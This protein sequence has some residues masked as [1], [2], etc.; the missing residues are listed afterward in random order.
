MNIFNYKKE[1]A[2]KIVEGY[3]RPNSFKSI[4]SDASIINLFFPK[5]ENVLLVYDKELSEDENEAIIEEYFI[6]CPHREFG[7]GEMGC[8]FNCINN[9]KEPIGI[10]I[11]PIPYNIQEGIMIFNPNQ[12][13]ILKDTIL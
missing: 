10:S 5:E 3:V 12:L 11:Y 7:G 9:H 8:T 13:E 2:I 6:G 4:E 1:V